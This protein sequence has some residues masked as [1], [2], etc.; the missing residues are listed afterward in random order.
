MEYINKTHTSWRSS[1]SW[2]KYCACLK[3][4]MECLGYI[5]PWII[6]GLLKYCWEEKEQYRSAER[7]EREVLAGGWL[8][9]IWLNRSAQNMGKGG[10][11][12]GL[13][14]PVTS[15]PSSLLPVAS[16]LGFAH[17]NPLH[18]AMMTITTTKLNFF[19]ILLKNQLSHKLNSDSW[20]T[21]SK[22]LIHVTVW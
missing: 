17:K 22:F 2:I 11:K 20:V 10:P 6:K 4:W 19:P 7:R 21:L 12:A 14:R 16:Q 1:I 3:G 18:T 8:T 9:E 5:N 13:G 15:F